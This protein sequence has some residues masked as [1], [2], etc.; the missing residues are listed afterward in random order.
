MPRRNSPTK[1]L[2]LSLQ[3]IRRNKKLS[4]VTVLIISLMLL[5]LNVV[6]VLSLILQS[7]LSSLSEKVDLIVYLS[8]NISPT[9]LTL[10]MEDLENSREVKEVQLTSSEEALENFLSLYQSSEN[11]F[12]QFDLENRL[13]AHLQITTITPQ[14]Q[15][16]VIQ[17][18][19]DGPYGNFIRSLESRDEN[20]LI[21]ERLI[22]I[23]KTIDS[24]IYAVGA[25]FLISSFL[26]IMSSIHL[27]LK[28]RKK[29]IQI[30]NLVGA[31][32]SMI[33]TPFLIEGVIYT[34][35]SLTLAL[36]GLGLFVEGLNLRPLLSTFTLKP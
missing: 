6:F 33:K 21:T 25:T 13:P 23:K 7:S 27:S 17:D 26:L 22:S 29:E 16:N 19:E 35:A 9:E 15:A 31:R 20:S 3:N 18:L 28:H 30:M 10:M 1:L 14:S 4:L 34:L 36:L 32:P 11:P 2:K 5:I 8:D 24:V 12:Q